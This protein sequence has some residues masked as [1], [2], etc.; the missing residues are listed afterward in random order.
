MEDDRYIRITLRI[1]KELHAHLTESA[2]TTS[3]SM[4]AEIVAR[5][6]ESF[7]SGTDH[8]FETIIKLMSRIERL[9]LQLDALENKTPDKLGRAYPQEST[10]IRRIVEAIDAKLDAREEALLAKMEQ[11][12]KRSGKD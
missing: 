8:Q 3:K 1:P 12:A 6:E 4:N 7:R 9:N 10:D 5:L 2:E 11:M